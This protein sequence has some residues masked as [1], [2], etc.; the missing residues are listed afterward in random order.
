[1]K[2]KPQ[3]I[4]NKKIYGLYLIDQYNHLDFINFNTIKL[5]SVIK[6]LVFKNRALFSLY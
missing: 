4:I 3:L 1:M 6:F 5:N 2:H